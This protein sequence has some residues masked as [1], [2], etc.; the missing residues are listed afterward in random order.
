MPA[1]S[2][3]EI[4]QYK[5]QLADY[6]E[7][8]AALNEIEECEGDLEDAAINLAIQVGQQPDCSDWLAGLA[9]RCR[10]QICAQDFEQELLKGNLIL[11]IDSLIKSKICP[12]ILVT[13]VVIYV[14][15]EGVSEFCQPISGVSYQ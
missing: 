5:T 11:V 8:I 1:I 9:K 10:A 13:P 2:I 6:P 14:L 7:A 12:P 4:F 15:K 3:E